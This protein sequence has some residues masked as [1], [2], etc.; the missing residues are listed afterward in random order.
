MKTSNNPKNIAA[1][2]RIKLALL[3][4]AGVI[5]GA[6]A[7]MFG[8]GRYGPYNWR[9]KQIALMEYASAIKRHLDAWI[10]GENVSLNAEGKPEAHP[11]GHVI[12]GAAIMLDAMEMGNAI[13][14]RPRRGPAGVLLRRLMDK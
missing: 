4:P 7:C 2:K 1:R 8:A 12:A 10:D 6:H 9:E 11:L 3:P 5:H 14:D 13:D